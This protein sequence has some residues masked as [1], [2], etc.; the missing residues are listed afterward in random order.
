[1]T[2]LYTISFVSN[3]IIYTVSDVFIY[4]DSEESVD[5]VAFWET[6]KQAK[7]KL[8]SIHKK[9]LAKIP[10]LSSNIFDDHVREAE[11]ACHL[12]KDINAFEEH[13]V[14]SEV[15]FEKPRL[16]LCEMPGIKCQGAYAK[17]WHSSG[18]KIKITCAATRNSLLAYRQ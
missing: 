5:V 1:M 18:E 12:I 9:L 14:G 16:I 3:G 13:V 15:I 7:K 11:F 6:Q 8:I 17:K 10:T 4:P 2:D